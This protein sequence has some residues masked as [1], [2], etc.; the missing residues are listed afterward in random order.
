MRIAKYLLIAF[1]SLVLLLAPFF[2]LLGVALFAPPAFEDSFVGIL[3]EKFE[4]LTAIEEDKI[5]VVG[6]SSVAF[7]IDSELLEKYLGMPVVNFGLYA[8]LG[9]KLMLD[10]SLAGIDEGD[11]VVISPEMD[12]E[13]LSLFFGADTVWR[14]IDGSPEMLQ[15]I[16]FDNY[17]AL[18]GALYGF[19]SS[20]LEYLLGDGSEINSGIYLSCYFDEYLDFD[21]PRENNVMFSYYEKNNLI[22]LNVDAYGDAFDEFIDYLNVY[23]E[24][25]KRRGAR[26]FFSPS[27]MNK[28]A[29]KGDEKTI[30]ELEDK[31]SSSLDCP[32]ISDFDDLILDAGYFFDTNFHLNEAGRRVR[33]MRLAEDLKLAAKILR[34]AITDSEPPIPELPE[35]EIRFDGVDEN[36]KYFTFET[37]D[38][39]AYIITG[40][41]EE[42]KLMT[43]LTL[44]LGYEGYIVESVGEG[45]F[46]G[47]SLES[48]TVSADSKIA[49]FEDGAFYG[50]GNLKRLIIYKKSG[51]EIL[52]PASFSGVNSQFT[53]FVPKGSDFS[54]HYYW[55]ERHVNFEYITE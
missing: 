33:T 15:Y 50:A 20:K 51:D 35:I 29:V 44:P 41:T 7:G 26:V 6:G 53:V 46:R 10:L 47:S 23:I 5:V 43:H 25:C 21:Y 36:V 16:D 18:F 12:E 34:P 2:L 45:A 52:P 39:G 22:E 13:A 37:S 4:R 27:S 31:L 11:I 28:M 49:Y 40:L 38:S 9:T 8:A 32:L 30:G 19:S 1:L 24:E 55:S 48:L 3:D 42:G 54:T 14:A 17:P